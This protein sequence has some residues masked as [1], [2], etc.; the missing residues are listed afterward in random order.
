MTASRL[1]RLRRN[2]FATG[3]DEARCLKK[4]MRTP[5]L[6][7]L[8]DRRV[9]ASDWQNPLFRL[10]INDDADVSP[11][12]ALVI[13][14][15]LNS[16]GSRTLNEPIDNNSPS[17]FYLD[18]NADGEVSPID[19]LLVINHLNERPT[20]LGASLDLAVDSGES[21][22]D[23]ITNDGRIR[24]QV[25]LNGGS[26]TMAR[27]RVNRNQVVDIP[28]DANGEFTI[29]PASI[30]GFADGEIRVGM[31]VAG[32]AGGQSLTQ[33][34]FT[35][36]T[37]APQLAPLALNA[38]DDTGPSNS[39]GVTRVAAPRLFVGAEAGS[40]VLV[41]INGS[42][43]IDEISSGPAER[44]LDTLPDG[45]YTIQASV[46]DVA[47]NTR[48]APPLSLV[49][50]T[51]A[52]TLATLDLA[53]TSDSGARGDKR[54]GAARVTLVGQTEP[55]LAVTVAGAA[56]TVRADGD[57]LF[58]VP[59]VA[60]QVGDNQFEAQAMDLAGNSSSLISTVTRAAEATMID[61]VLRWNQAALEAIR[62]DA[63]AP[64]VATR[65]LAMMAIAMLDVVNAVEGTASY[66]VSLKPTGDVAI[67]AAI[68]AAAAE[69]LTY[70]YPAQAAAI[71]TVHNAVL[72][73]VPDGDAE[74]AGVAF[75]ELVGEAVIA[76]R[77]NDGWNRFV[78]HPVGK[79]LGDWQPTAPMFDVP[80][81]PQWGQLT[82]FG[83][84][85][86]A[87]M[88]P[89]G[90]PELASAEY[91]AALNEV[92]SLGAANS[93][94]RTADQTEIARFWADGAGSYTPPGHWNQIA[95]E[96]AQNDELSVGEN[97]R[98]FAMLNIAL[99]DAGIVAWNVKYGFDFW[100]P[101]TAIQNAALDGNL[102]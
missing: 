23:Q 2:L 100:R 62:S 47:G 19:V 97:A 65:G 70:L 34:R 55:N 35:L 73:E 14:N 66:L 11:I 98:L 13:I 89:A 25:D 38:A 60:L 93:T 40:H 36:D 24:G 71:Q 74:T 33:L 45:A 5:L 49:I 86:V 78:E 20:Q 58:R 18:S 88:S 80:L 50:D 3:I 102:D 48:Q 27:V 63:T 59:N 77:A 7:L 85:D 56:Q 82:P 90:P 83:I 43:E 8:E 4:R 12:D 91:A 101:I 87:A 1:R 30:E 99:G 75:G 84:A 61:P 41:D 76:L 68:S 57:G 17:V 44:T 96:L 9:F 6:E 16:N 46:R 10:D 69:V 51:A 26:A 72:A 54:T 39:D 42:T 29:D 15:D 22:T 37:Q 52:P 81:L 28:I 53:E 94:T 67:E 31:F 79:E 95:L 32:S 64:P 92:K 21:N